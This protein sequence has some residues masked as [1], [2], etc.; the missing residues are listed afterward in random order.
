VPPL[1]WDL[2]TLRKAWN[3]AKGHV[4]PWWPACSKEAYASGIA[5]LAQAPHN[6]SESKQGRRAGGRVEFPQLSVGLW[7]GSGT[8][9]SER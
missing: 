2:P 7:A 8:L 3:Q 9:V 5:D 6:W 4:A 1:A